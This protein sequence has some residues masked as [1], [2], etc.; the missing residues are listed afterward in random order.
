MCSN[1]FRVDTTFQISSPWKYYFYKHTDDKNLEEIY[2]EDFIFNV[3]ED[4][5]A[6][7]SSYSKMLEIPECN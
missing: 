4:K 7:F 6:F 5:I 2:F 1:M 3:L